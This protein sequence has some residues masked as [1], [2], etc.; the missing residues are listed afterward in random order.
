MH[1]QYD[2]LCT[3]GFQKGGS[4]YGD[5]QC[6]KCN[7]HMKP[8]RCCKHALSS[9]GHPSFLYGR[10]DVPSRGAAMQIVAASIMHIGCLLAS[11]HPVLIVCAG[12]HQKNLC[13]V[14]SLH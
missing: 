12:H 4:L 10:I 14:I 6:V 9:R 5:A 7:L 11:T 2:Y 13:S 1:T 3:K 8:N